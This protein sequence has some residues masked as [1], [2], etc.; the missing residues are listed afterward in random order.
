MPGNDPIDAEARP[1]PPKTVDLG[2]M[3]PEPPKPPGG[4]ERAPDVAGGVTTRPGEA[5]QAGKP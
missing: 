3:R 2:E 4:E 5:D 1:E